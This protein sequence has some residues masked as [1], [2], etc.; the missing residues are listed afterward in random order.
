MQLTSEELEAQV[1]AIA[2]HVLRLSP[3]GIGIEGCIF[4]QRVVVPP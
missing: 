3:T 2:L 1:A 4:T